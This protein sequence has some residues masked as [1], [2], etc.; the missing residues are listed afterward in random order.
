[1][2][3]ANAEAGKHPVLPVFL[4]LPLQQFRYFTC[5][6]DTSFSTDCIRREKGKSLSGALSKV[7]LGEI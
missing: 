4:M 7:M 6:F 5:G 3:H 2:P 1:L